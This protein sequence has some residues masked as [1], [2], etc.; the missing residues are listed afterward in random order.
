MT[1]AMHCHFPITVRVR[2]TPD[3]A[4]FAELADRVR[5]QV[6][7]RLADAERALAEHESGQHAA[8]ETPTRPRPPAR[9]IAPRPVGPDEAAVPGRGW[10]V[11]RAVTIT[12]SVGQFLDYCALVSGSGFADRVLLADLESDTR[13]VT[14]W[15]VETEATTTLEDLAGV[16]FRRAR[17]LLRLTERDDL[18]YAASPYD[19]AR[20]TLATLDASGS[21]RRLPPLT[22][23]NARR[24]DGTG[25]GVQLLHGAWMLWAGMRLPHVD[26]A[27]WL[28]LGTLV[29]RRL[30]LTDVADGI[31]T[32]TFARAHGVE[33]SDYLAVVI[34]AQ[35]DLLGFRIRRDSPADAVR[36][37]AL[38][39]YREQAG[40]QPGSAD[41]PIGDVY[42]VGPGS[43]RLV[44]EYGQEYARDLPPLPQGQERP[45]SHQSAGPR[46]TPGAIGVVLAVHLPVDAETLGAAR[47]RRPAGPLA[48]R[49]RILLAQVADDRYRMYTLYDWLGGTFGDDPPDQ[50]PAGGTQFEY[51]LAD[52]A[53]TGD[54]GRL[55]DVVEDTD[56]DGLSFRLLQLCLATRFATDPRVA[57]LLAR[58][59]T[60]TLAT[61]RNT[62]HETTGTDPGGIDLG[63]D[64][65]RAV[66]I[67]GRDV[68]GDANSL[69]LTSS[70]QRFL[71]PDA[72]TRLRT[73]FDEERINVVADVATGRLARELTA[74]D[75]AREA[76][77][78]AAA[79]AHITT[80]DFVTRTVERSIRLTGVGRRD[81]AHLPSWDITFCFVERVKGNTAWTDVSDPVH[82]TSDEFTARLIYWALGRTGEFY[83]TVGLAITVIGGLAIAWEAGVVALLVEL[84]GGATVVLTSIAISEV[85]YIIQRIYH[86]ERP[87]LEGVLMAAVDG[88]LG[89]LGFRAASFVAAPIGRAIGTATLTRVWTGIVAEKLVVGVV[90]GGT[91]AAMSLF[92]HDVVDVMIHDGHFHSGANYL[93][94]VTTGMAVGVLAEFTLSPVLHRLGGAGFA[95]RAQVADLVAQLRREGFALADL[96][97]AST[98]ALSRLR[99]AIADILVGDAATA[100]LAAFR[101]RIGEIITSWGPSVVARRVLE[102]SGARFTLQA[103]A[104]LRVFLTAAEEPGSAEAARRL[105]AQFADHPQEAVHLLEVLSTLDD[106]AARSLMTG[107]FRTPDELAAFLGRLSRYTADQQRG[108]LAMLGDL[109][110]DPGLAS[111]PAGQGLPPGDVLRRQAASALRVEARQ[112]EIDAA[113]LRHEAQDRLDE[114]VLRAGDN[115]RRSD[116][117]LDKAAALEREAAARE[118]LSAE[119]AAGRDPRPPGQRVPDLHSATEAEVS[120]DVDRVFAQ[121]EAGAGTRRQPWIRLPAHR[122]LTP[123][124]TDALTRTM[125]TSRS[126]N[127]VVFRVEGGAGADTSRSFITVRTG[128][129]VTVGT[130]GRD[131]NLNVGSFE[132]AVEFMI[133]HRP[134][135][136]LKVFEVEAAWLR[137][138]RGIATPEQGVPARVESVD[139]ATGAR[140]QL[141]SGGSLR[142]VRGTAR[143]V[144]TR[145]AADQL[146]I[147]GSLVPELQEFIVEGT[148]RELIFLPRSPGGRPR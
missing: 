54:L 58:F 42:L 46:V 100:Y 43:P 36:F 133:A 131:L 69:Y 85:I 7:A 141:P 38:R 33:W 120:A 111:R 101:Q 123:P 48:A 136:T 23:R 21:I 28:D 24:L 44:N 64:S 12:L 124:E 34:Q 122:G 99:T 47:Y 60:Q 146:Q 20:Q 74:E 41:Q 113:Q 109:A 135:S 104:G 145:Q 121:L 55:F 45:P 94:V 5:H 32:D 22:R 40:P 52:L 4:Q 16:V 87:T 68:L 19:G 93:R 29:T 83:E 66:R 90:G 53:G 30:P 138:L 9:R 106:G 79:R 72:A 108:I 116:A 139:P 56:W 75:F 117:L 118:Q 110:N 130:G 63:H 27:S 105:A 37:L 13:D 115:P 112:A 57:G 31:D 6:A 88:Y 51:V 67:G 97:A 61:L 26:P 128:G 103:E 71:K 3:D 89:A 39:A 147:D 81:I 96:A 92:A 62:F 119:L 91:S 70:D 132:R 148:G 11:L 84:G 125:F 129:D 78:R 126:G 95:P 1:A 49:L 137:N 134:G 114:A 8:A 73:A 82:E 86:G 142:D 18:R 65:G 10:R 35:V 77:A 107:T 102:L 80:D 14:V 127:P 2:G 98:A 59:R 50:R 76:L 140:R 17:Q 143:T 25:S 15:L 144:D